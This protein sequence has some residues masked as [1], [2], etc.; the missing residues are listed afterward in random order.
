[1]NP[2][3]VATDWLYSSSQCNQNPPVSAKGKVAMTS[4]ASSN[5]PNLT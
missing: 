5:R 1:M 3:A 4:N 2:T